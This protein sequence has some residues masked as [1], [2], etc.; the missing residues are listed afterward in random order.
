MS[1]ER[2]LDETLLFVREMDFGTTA[3]RTPVKRGM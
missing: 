3:N 1:F 2:N